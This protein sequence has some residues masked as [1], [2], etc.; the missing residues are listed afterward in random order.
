MGPE[1][2]A[3][4][5]GIPVS[6]FAGLTLDKI[7]TFVSSLKD[8]SLEGLFIETFYVALDAQKKDYPQGVKKLKKAIKEKEEECIE[9]FS[10]NLDNYNSLISALQEKN[11]HKTVARQVVRT[12]LSSP[13]GSFRRAYFP[14]RAV[15]CA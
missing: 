5:L 4:L 10:L 14:S 2:L 15:S 11:F 3:A 7:K 12:S 8:V 1:I 13:E 9:I 6:W